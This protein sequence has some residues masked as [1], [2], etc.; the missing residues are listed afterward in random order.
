MLHDRGGCGV[1]STNDTKRHAG[2]ALAL[3]AQR[4]YERTVKDRQQ[5]G[6]CDCDVGSRH[7]GLPEVPVAYSR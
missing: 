2:R 1:W 6:E 4:A 7:E 5:A 3:Q